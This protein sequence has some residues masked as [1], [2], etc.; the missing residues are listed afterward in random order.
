M[1]QRPRLRALALALGL[2]G[3]AFGA[4]PSLAEPRAAAREEPAFY[5]T[6]LAS[7]YADRFHGR[8]TASGDRFRQDRLTAASRALP[9][10]AVV[11]V[12]NADTQRSVLVRVN[13]RGPHI[14]GRVIDLSRSA[15]EAIGLTSDDGVASVLIEAR[16]SAQPSAWLRRE[17]ARRAR[18]QAAHRP[19]APAEKPPIP[20][21]RG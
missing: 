2:A 16:P 15:A 18:L 3:L 12:T 10:G 17:I 9:L 8:R 14:A 1:P 7:R 20:E 5:Q 13:D 21:R 4:P 11:K 6:G 19:P